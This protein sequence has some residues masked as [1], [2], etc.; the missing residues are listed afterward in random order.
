MQPRRRGR[1]HQHVVARMELHL[2]NAVAQAVV[3][4]ELRREHIGQARMGLHL[5]TAHQ[6]AER[7]QGRGVERGCVEAQRIQHRPVASKQVHI[8]QRRR[9]VKD[10]M[11]GTHDNSSNKRGD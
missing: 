11:R 1:R 10:F 8:H 7:M 6:G 9:L 4:L 2:I 3:A 5:G